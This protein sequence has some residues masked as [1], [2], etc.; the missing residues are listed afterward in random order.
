[1]ND[2]N[3]SVINQLGLAAWR[4]IVASLSA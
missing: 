3:S 1:M 4:L 2:T